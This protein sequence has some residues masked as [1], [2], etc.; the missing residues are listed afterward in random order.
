MIIMLYVMAEPSHYLIVFIVT[1]AM[2]LLSQFL[3]KKFGISMS[4]QRATQAR[5]QELQQQLMEAQRMD[6][7]EARRL[8]Q[9]SM[10]MMNQMMRKQLIPSLIRCVIFWVFFFVLTAVFAGLEFFTVPILIF[11]QGV[12]A[13]YFIYSIGISLLLFL[14][15][16][17]RKRTHPNPEADKNAPV[18]DVAKVL[19]GAVR[20]A[21]P[22]QPSYDNSSFGNQVSSLG[23]EDVKDDDGQK[24]WKKKLMGENGNIPSEQEK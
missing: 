16:Y 22:N 1:L 18:T 20:F 12:V 24:S 4:N 23:S 6:P 14:V 5:M 19:G 8:Q 21:Q 11:G 10:V 2:M 7:A 13:I 17:I 3:N 9:E 15:K